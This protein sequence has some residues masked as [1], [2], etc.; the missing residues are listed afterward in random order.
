MSFNDYSLR[1]S[2]KLEHIKYSLL[3][4]DGPQ[5]N[6]FSDIHLV[7]NCMI[8]Y[9][10]SDVSLNTKLGEIFLAHPIIINAIT[11]GDDG[12]AKINK[13]L[14]TAAK[15]TNSAMAVGS[16][17]AAIKN[18]AVK[19]SY[20]VV[21]EVNPDGVVF[22]N[23]GAYASLQD[24][25]DVVKMVDAQALQIHLNIAQELAM[26]EGD[27]DFKHWHDN[28]KNIIDKVNVPVIIKETGCGIAME[29]A[30]QLLDCGAKI[31]DVSGSG[32]SNFIAI[33]TARYED[34]YEDFSVWGINTAIS[35]L[36]VKQAVGKKA[37][38][39]VSGGLR[40]AVDIVKAL[41]CGGNAVGISLLFLKL[42]QNNEDE[43]V[44]VTKIND[45]LETSKKLLLLAGCSNIE[46]LQKKPLV[47][48]GFVREW[49]VARGIE[50]NSFNKS[51]GSK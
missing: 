36:E 43:E 38:I 8:D 30:Q 10:Y 5:A 50:I 9:D 26:Q 31:I 29:Q 17:Y 48:T 45:L 15:K 2:R 46:Q 18:P 37:D 4:G 22:A 35:T 39:V 41:A 51:R 16:Q 23:I 12:V 28:I 32:G 25:K 44:L 34:C 13:K 21:R 49:L 47:I 33:E 14:A 11:G 42:L 19:N 3:T 6:G 27:R 20:T 24:A 1:Q 40:S 7:H